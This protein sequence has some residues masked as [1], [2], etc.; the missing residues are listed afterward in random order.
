MLSRGEGDG[1][2]GRELGAISAYLPGRSAWRTVVSPSLRKIEE[3][4]PT[5]HTEGSDGI[6][7]M[8]APSAYRS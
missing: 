5:W 6:G 2:A 4:C 3:L 7:S 1:R 8:H